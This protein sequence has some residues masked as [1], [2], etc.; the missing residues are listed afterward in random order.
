M[1]RTSKT[2][3]IGHLYPRQ[4][5]IYGD[6]GNVLTLARRAQW[7][8]YETKIIDI[9]PGGTIDTSI[10]LLVG[11]GGQDS[12]QTLIQD[13]L[14]RLGDT[15]HTLADQKLPMLMICGLY[16]LFG[17]FFQTK[18]GTRI[19]GI[20]VFDIETY[21]GDHRM[22][23]NVVTRTEYGDIIGYENHSGLTILGESQRPFGT[24]I[25][26]EGNNGQD[27]TEGAIYKH[28]FGSYLHGS[29]LPK[30]PEFADALIEFA[31]I[32]RFGDFESHVI[33]DTF[34]LHAREIARNRPR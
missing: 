8:G 23:G 7:H 20:G 16:Q 3:V 25:K 17:H 30:N 21:G 1:T 11:G 12:G 28:V 26:G 24:I 4:M 32:R 27:K 22:I 33:D 13:D 6:W 34:A 9:N 31:A 29:L 19:Q 14:L 18:D 15:I 5:N 10:D 2:L